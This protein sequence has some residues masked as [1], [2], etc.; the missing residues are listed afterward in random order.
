ME[1]MLVP[2]RRRA[3]VA[4]TAA[5]ACSL[6]AGCGGGRS[7]TVTVRAPTVSTAQPS[8]TRLV[9][10]DESG[11][12]RIE[13]TSCEGTDTGTGFLIGPRLVATVDHVTRGNS[14]LVL[15]QHGKIVATG[16]VIG[17]DE[18]RDVALVETSAPLSGHVFKLASR[19]PEVGQNVA[20]LGF[21]L[22]LPLTVTKGSVSGL[23]RTVP[24]DG[25]ERHRLVQT[26]AAVN[27]G[28]SGG[29]LIS[30]ESGEVVGLVD[31]G[32][33]E[34]NGTAFAVSAEVAGPLLAAWRVAPQTEPVSACEP[35]PNPTLTPQQSSTPSDEE[36]IT[37]TLEQHF[38]EIQ[39]G[40]DEAAWQDFTPAEAARLGSEE[41]WIQGQREWDLQRFTLNVQAEVT[42]A[43]SGIA[44]VTDF[45]TESL[46]HG[47]QEW[48]GHWSVELSEAG[49]WQIALAALTPTNCT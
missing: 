32:T 24:I 47:C 25:T 11:I 46:G 31:L 37:Y 36:A 3:G 20:A 30:T 10:A 1:A 23:D 29:P 9:A 27:P 19:A 2:G 17:D 49:A 39:A 21:P 4:I 45:R 7:R 26:D 13:G 28:N 15:K 38:N 42:S 6:L 5:L 16:K 40:Q 33:S 22:G 18:A 34:A 41:T 12:V 8:F 43:R 14:Q 48:K 35:G 44:S